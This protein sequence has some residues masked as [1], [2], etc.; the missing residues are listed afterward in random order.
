MLCIDRI[1]GPAP[2]ALIGER[3]YENTPRINFAAPCVTA[4]PLPLAAINARPDILT[5]N[6]PAEVALLAP[7]D[8]QHFF[9]AAGIGARL[10][11]RPLYGQVVQIAGDEVANLDLLNELGGGVLLRVGG[12]QPL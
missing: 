5:G 12:E 3:A 7:V 1:N 2:T 4:L 6:G 8:N 9:H 10:Q 11:H